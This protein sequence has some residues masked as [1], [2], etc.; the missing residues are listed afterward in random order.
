[1]AR[2]F[3]INGS[4]FLEENLVSSISLD[5]VVSAVKAG[6]RAW[7]DESCGVYR[8]L[9]RNLAGNYVCCAEDSEFFRTN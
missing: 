7:I 6:G 1:M 2:E 8:V 5:M 9:W 3:I 4:M